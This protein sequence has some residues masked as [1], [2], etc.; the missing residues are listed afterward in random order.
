MNAKDTPMWRIWAFVSFF[1][2]L[3]LTITGIWYLLPDPVLKGA[4]TMAILYIV[5]ASITITKVIRDLYEE[6]KSKHDELS[7]HDKQ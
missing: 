7:G 6:R 4:L 1:G 2:S 3:I 5:Q